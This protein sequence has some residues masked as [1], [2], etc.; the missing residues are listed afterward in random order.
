[1]DGL[2]RRRDFRLLWLG[3]STSR[4]GSNVSAVALPLVAVV[5]LDADAFTVGLL[6]AAAWVPWLV[7]GLPAGAWVDRV[8]RRPLMM[9][10]DLVAA[11]LFLSVPVAAWLGVLSVP[12]LLTVALLAGA[13]S[14]FFTTAYRVY[15]PTVVPD[16]QLGAGNAMLRGSESAAQIAGRGLGGVL[17][18]VFGAVSGLLA[19]AATFVVSFF[20]LLSIR[21]IEAPRTGSR[22]S[23]REEIGTGLRWTLGDPWLRALAVFGCVANLGLTGFQ[24]LQVLFVTRDLGAGP[25]VVGIVVASSGIGGVVGAICATRITRRFGTARGLLLCLTTTLPFL[26][27]IPVAAPG[28]GVLLA[29][30]GNLVPAAGIVAANVVIAA[31][32]QTYPPPGLRG[33]VVATA[34]VVSYAA[35]P[36]GAVLGGALA[37]VLGV[38]PAIGIMT[39][40]VLA[41]GVLLVTSPLRRTRELPAMPPKHR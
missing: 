35:D 10:C 24:A 20:S 14:V 16:A 23:L 41:A 7:L 19:D 18:Q 32:Q 34:N 25:A 5:T 2:L 17:A 36:V 27:L 37:T 4:L 39:G 3:Q 15:L 12:H 28:W 9:A 30:A 22:S 29:V 33:R 6:A 8:A 26:L 1:M 13:A 40:V 21:A 31:F 38:R 11:A